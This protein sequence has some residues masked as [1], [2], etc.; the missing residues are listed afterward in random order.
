MMPR[1]THRTY[2]L[3]GIG[4]V[5]VL[6]IAV[7]TL[8]LGTQISSSAQRALYQQ[9]ASVVTAE[10]NYAVAHAGEYAQQAVDLATADP[11]LGFLLGNNTPVVAF[12]NDD[13]NHGYYFELANQSTG[14]AASFSVVM[15]DNDTAVLT[16]TGP[17]PLCSDGR[18]QLPHRDYALDTESQHELYEQAVTLLKAERSYAAS[19]GSYAPFVVDLAIHDRDL[20]FM[21]GPDTSVTTYNSDTGGHG[22][23]AQ[24]TNHPTGG[25]ATFSVLI[26]DHGAPVLTCVG[27]APLC[28]HGTF[29]VPRGTLAGAAAGHS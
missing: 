29:K 11:K 2:W 24:L 3:V 13:G 25:S 5:I 21:A 20:G 7:T 8:H 9:T 12:N 28:S 17:G 26:P 16:C 19:R 23:Y 6:L 27:A 14:G 1:I 15:S 4:A 22:Y 18:F 10:R